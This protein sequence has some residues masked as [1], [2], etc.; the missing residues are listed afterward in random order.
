M[1]MTPEKKK[2]DHENAKDVRVG[3][4][5]LFSSEFGAVFQ[6]SLGRCSIAQKKKPQ[7][8]LGACSMFNVQFM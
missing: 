5:T 2:V 6:E 8:G 7:E 3:S 4:S 1:A